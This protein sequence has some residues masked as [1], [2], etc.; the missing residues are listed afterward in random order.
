MM[1]PLLLATWRCPHGTFPKLDC[2][3]R[4]IRKAAAGIVSVCEL[5]A[6]RFL[7]GSQQHAAPRLRA[8][9]GVGSLAV[10][11]GL[12]NPQENAVPAQLPIS[13]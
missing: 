9:V 3:G 13:H 10:S 8:H 7:L 5:H 6:A 12:E 4:F 1:R 11:L 2:G